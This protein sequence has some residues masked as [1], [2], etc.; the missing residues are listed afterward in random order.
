MKAKKKVTV[1]LVDVV[2]HDRWS[3]PDTLETKEFTSEKRAEAFMRKINSKN[4]APSAPEY[5]VEAH[6]SRRYETTR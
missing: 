1:I 5:Y 2:E 3:G 4:T 6:V